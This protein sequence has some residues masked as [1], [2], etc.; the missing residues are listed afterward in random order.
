VAQAQDKAMR[1]AQVMA[2][3][4]APGGATA[5]GEA[6]PQQN[7]LVGMLPMIVAFIAI[8]YFFMIRPNQKREKERRQMLSSLTK[9][10][11]VVTSGGV[12]GTVVGLSDKTVVLKVDDDS[13]VKIEF[14]R[15]AISQVTARGNQ[16]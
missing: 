12:C 10:D 4:P 13:N 2:D 3:Q 1:L 16:G 11:K 6:I 15:G 5:P 9:G 14:L 8:M 7:P